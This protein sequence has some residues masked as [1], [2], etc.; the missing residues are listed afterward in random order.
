MPRVCVVDLL[1]C[2]YS[3]LFGAIAYRLPCRPNIISP[4]SALTFLFALLLVAVIS[5]WYLATGF[6]TRFLLAMWRRRAGVESHCVT[7]D[8]IRWHFLKGG[9]GRTLL[10]LHG[11]GADT[12]CWL[13]LATLIRQRF[14][15]LIPDLPGFG[16]SEPPEQLKF[17]IDTQVHR[18]TAFLDELGVEECLVAGNSMGGYLAAALAASEPS[19]I[20]AL[21]LLAPLGVTTAPPGKLLEEIDAGETQAGQVHSVQHF[22]QEFLPTMFSGKVRLPYPLMRSQ[23]ENAIS[24]RD[25]VSEMLAEVRLKS[26]PLQSI[27]E[28]IQQP[29]LLQWGD[30]D[31]IVNPAGLTVLEETLDNAESAITKNCGHLPMIEKAGESARLFLGFIEKNRLQ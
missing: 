17:D 25:V 24:R 10:L 31:Q 21:W 27:A 5:S 4:M 13:P 1:I 9:K 29:V 15:L 23:A 14:T 11:F 20:R 6:W 19:R 18:L 28:R 8:G 12:S 2:H 7:V 30:E 26:E 3:S 22:R 16:E